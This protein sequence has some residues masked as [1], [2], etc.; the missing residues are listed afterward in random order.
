MTVWTRPASSNRSAVATL[1]VATALLLL[2]DRVLKAGGIAPAWLTG[3]LSDFAGLLVAPVLIA[4]LL[5]AL[6]VARARAATLSCASVGL[7]FAALKLSPSCA[8]AFD[9]MAGAALRCLDPDLTSRTVADP[10]DLLALP[11]LVLARR[12]AARVQLGRGLLLRAGLCVAAFACLGTSSPP[13]YVGPHWGLAG[14]V[15]RAFIPFEHGLLELRL[16]RTSLEGS[17]ELG[18]VVYAH[19][20]EVTLPAGSVTAWLD[21]ARVAARTVPRGAPP[22]IVAPGR[23]GATR[24]YFQLGPPR[25]R[26]ALVD[27]EPDAPARAGTLQVRLD[28]DGA[29][30]TITVPLAYVARVE[31]GLT[32][33]RF[34]LGRVP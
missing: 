17:F 30:K 29:C 2:N 20:A 34:A 11:V 21:G 25:D 3:K 26:A 31:R 32:L 15:E 5:R 18:L 24:V 33:D 10:S 6:G 19:G 16:G 1:F 8:A 13:T 9:A 4:L 28:Y 12:I 27:F 14:D 7:G 22:L 23:A